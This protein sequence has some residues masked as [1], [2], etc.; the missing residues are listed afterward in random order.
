MDDEL[1]PAGLVEKAF[2][3]DRLERRQRAQRDTRRRKIIHELRRC[4]C[5]EAG[6]LRNLLAW[7]F[8]L[9]LCRY[10]G[11]QTRDRIRELVGPPRCFSEPERNGGRLA[12]RILDAHLAGLDAQDPIRSVA[13]LEDVAGQ[14]FDGKVL[15]DRPDLLS[16]R[17]QHH[18]V[19]RRIRNGASG[20]NRGESCATPPAHDTVH[21][22]AMQVG[23]TMTAPGA[24]AIGEHPH[25]RG[26]LTPLEIGERIG[27]PKKLE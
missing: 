8:A 12:M 3:H 21:R 24:Q 15:V 13:K 7:R 2:E 27:T 14:T 25:H 9:E 26:I 6:P 1:H 23:G 19:I 16:C 20:R 22:V 11:A 4:R 5:S 18:V 17:F 10:I